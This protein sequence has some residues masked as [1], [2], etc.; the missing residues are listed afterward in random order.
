MAQNGS[1]TSQN[2]CG[3]QQRLVRLVQVSMVAAM[4]AVAY[5]IGLYAQ[6]AD[7][8]DASAVVKYLN[9]AIT[10]YRQTNQQQE[11]ATEPSDVLVLGD[12]RQVADQVVRL[13]FEFARAEAASISKQGTGN[14]VDN[15]NPAAARY[16]SLAQLSAKFDTQAKELQGEIDTLRQ[17]LA[18]ATGKQRELLKNDLAE[19]QSELE[20]VQVRRDTL[21]SMVEFVSGASAAGVGATG[22]RAQIEALARS[23]PAANAQNN[24]QGAV[25]D[26]GTANHSP[27]SVSTEALTTPKPSGIWGLTADLISLSQKIA[28]LEAS[29]RATDELADA[30]KKLRAPIVADLKDLTKKS[31][32]I[33]NQ[34]DTAHN[35]AQFAEQKQQLEALT[36][37][38]KQI[39]A[40]MLPLSKQGILLSI[41]R[42]NVSN[43]QA[44]LRG[45]SRSE[46][47]GLLV[48]LGVLALALLLVYAFAE[49]W[50][51]TI[52]RYVH[53]PRRRYQF[54]LLRKIVLWFVI[55]IVIAFAFA[56]QLGSVAT[57]AGL[58]TAGVAVA[59]QNVILSIAGYFFLIGRFGIRV[60]DR[61][62]VAGVTGEVVEVGLVRL[63]LMELAPG[64][65]S[66]TGRVVAFSNSIVFQPTSGL[67]KQIPGTSFLWHEITL[68][69]APHSDYHA[70]EERLL[71]AVETVFKDYQEEMERQR[72]HLERVLSSGSVTS[73]KPRA[74]LHFTGTGLDVSIKFP[75]SLQKATEIDDRVTRELLQAINREPKLK[76]ADSSAPVIRLNTE[77]ATPA[78]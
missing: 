33:A 38:F 73:L 4:L 14:S 62:Q 18:G 43:W 55:V 28:V 54:L 30:A 67:F 19:T 64:S 31:D 49:A 37:Q 78:S 24:G 20:L 10:W 25:A 40:A 57:F 53:D 58:I 17:K 56:S 63:H 68:T 7:Q 72:V 45:R 6:P 65:D 51:R 1:T 2:T 74:R 42:A 16:Q 77:V 46:L 59:L 34:A 47:R 48:R 3:R 13:A 44:G 50:R 35:P 76:L 36:A 27:N 41:Y 52:F 69:L 71:A 5:G 26:N 32:D 75:V 8:T 29:I 70:V 39:S 9:Q 15:Q 66:P 23:V 22:L 61:V 11:L 12:N 60:G 21:K